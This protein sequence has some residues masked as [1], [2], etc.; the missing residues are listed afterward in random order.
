[1]SSRS[2]SFTL[3]DVSLDIMPGERVGIVGQNGAGNLAAFS[4]SPNPL[5]DR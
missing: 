4:A 3:D 2:R 1:M 5:K